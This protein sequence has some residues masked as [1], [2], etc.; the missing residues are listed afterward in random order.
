MHICISTLF[1]HES[2]LD[3]IIYWMG[4]FDVNFWEVIDERPNEL[5]DRTISAY[6]S[7]AKLKGLR[8]NVHSI[9]DPLSYCDLWLERLK[10]TIEMASPLRP[11]YVVIHLPK[12]PGLDEA[13]DSLEK[14]SSFASRYGTSILVENCTFKESNYFN[15]IDDF[16]YLFS[17]CADKRIGMC[18]DIGHAGINGEIDIYMKSFPDRIKEI[19]LHDNDGKR[20]LH[21]PLGSGSIPWYRIVDR[22]VKS[23]YDGLLT[24][25]C[26]FGIEDSLEKLTKCLV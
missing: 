18:L 1:T 4:R 10:R 14:L 22:F 21:L 17:T 26:K 8:F 16:N 5:E 7:I 3:R 12:V 20:D 25:E 6:L 9:F 24:L 13:I 2:T 15:S 23:G 11:S 19:H